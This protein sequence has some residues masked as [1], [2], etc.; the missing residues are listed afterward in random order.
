MVRFQ[1]MS[2]HNAFSVWPPRRRRRSMVR[3]MIAAVATISL[4]VGWRFVI[5]SRVTCQ[6][7][8]HLCLILYSSRSI[9]PLC[10]AGATHVGRNI[11]DRYRADASPDARRSDRIIGPV[12]SLGHTHYTRTFRAVR[13]HVLRGVSRRVV[14]YRAGSVESWSRS[15]VEWPW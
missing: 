4:V 5:F 13:D 9:R 1:A 7:P 10:T 15:S 11:T 2:R 14:P 3:G 12:S 8:P 6:S